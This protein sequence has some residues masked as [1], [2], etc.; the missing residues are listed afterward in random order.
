M[1]HAAPDEA[2]YVASL[3]KRLDANAEGDLY[4]DDTCI[5]CGTCR[6]VA[7]ENFERCGEKS[8]VYRQPVPAGEQQR[9][10]MALLACPVAAIGTQIKHNLAT[11]RKAFPERV[12]GTVY[13]CGYHSYKSFGAASYFIRRE[14]GNVLID[15]PRFTS[16]LVKRLEQLGGIRFLFLSHIDDIADHDKFRRHFRCKR[17]MHS[18]D[19]KA[20][21]EH[22]EIQLTGFDPI[23]FHS[24]FLFIPIPR[25]AGMLSSIG[26][27]SL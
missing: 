27:M 26:P 2:L 9:A 4:V 1:L 18:A 3:T 5:D 16:P 10:L 13:H 19:A 22:I 7:P 6:W 8:R 24:D 15:S 12:D 17:I 21:D 23:P 11:A 14:Q 25:I 20:V